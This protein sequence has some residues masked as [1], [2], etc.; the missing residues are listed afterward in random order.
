M[1][2]KSEEEEMR[3]RSRRISER[4]TAKG[5]EREERKKESAREREREGGREGGRETE[6]ETESERE[7]ERDR[8]PAAHS[9]LLGLVVTNNSF[10]TAKKIMD[11]VSTL[12]LNLALFALGGLLGLLVVGL[13]ATFFFTF[14]HGGSLLTIITPLSLFWCHQQFI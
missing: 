5:G 6:T 8:D 3:V 14:G 12:R 11:C 4:E 10:I 1:D 9:F 7:R 2:S 13:F